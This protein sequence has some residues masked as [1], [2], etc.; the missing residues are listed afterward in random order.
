MIA[1]SNGVKTLPQLHVNNKLIG[2]FDQLQELEDW[3]E[4]DAALSGR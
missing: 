4:L 2:N 3:G 1:H